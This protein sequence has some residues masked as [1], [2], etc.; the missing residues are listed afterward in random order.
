[1][2]RE[3]ST[4]FR[5]RPLAAAIALALAAPVVLAEPLFQV[6][7]YG[8]ADMTRYE[9]NNVEIGIA[10]AD[11]NGARYRFGEWNGLFRDDAF[12]IANFNWLSRDMT[13]G[14]YWTVTGANLGADKMLGN[15]CVNCH[16]KVHG[17]N[18]PAGARFTR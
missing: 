8:N 11:V 15:A 6:P 2:N 18:H 14:R 10:G 16:V 4:A 9:T 13:S 17:S 3:H 1:M 12:A 5:T 7:L